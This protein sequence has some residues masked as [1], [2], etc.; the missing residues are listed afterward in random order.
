MNLPKLLLLSLFCAAAVSAHPG[1]SP[2]E[3]AAAHQLTHSEHW[4]S[5]LLITALCSLIHFV[6]K[7]KL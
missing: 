2:L 5:L 6:R 3:N 1:H 7:R 4:I